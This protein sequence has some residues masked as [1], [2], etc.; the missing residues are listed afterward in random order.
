MMLLQLMSNCDVKERYTSHFFCAS[1]F[2]P[3]LHTWK[4]AVSLILILLLC[5][6]L[7]WIRIT[8]GL[9]SLGLSRF[10][11]GF[12]SWLWLEPLGDIHKPV[13]KLLG[14]VP[15]VTIYEGEIQVVNDE[16]RRFFSLG[17]SLYLTTLF[18]SSILT[19]V[20]AGN[21]HIP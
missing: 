9:L 14:W 21:T 20:A 12:K 16:F 3:V 18:A 13:L 19:K 10:S 15:W 2:T 11:V 6:L 1:G 8:G 7:D 17:M 4:H 5:P